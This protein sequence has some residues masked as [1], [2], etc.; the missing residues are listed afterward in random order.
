[1]VEEDDEYVT[2]RFT[3]T[4]AILIY[5]PLLGLL[6]SLL[7]VARSLRTARAAPS[8]FEQ[9]VHEIESDR[10]IEHE[11]QATT[12]MSSA[13]RRIVS[14][15]RHPDTVAPVVLAVT[16]KW[17]SGKSSLMNLVGNIL[18]TYHFP[19]VW[20]NAWHHQNE[21]HL[22]ASLLESIRLTVARQSFFENVEFRTNLLRQRV[23]PSN[24]TLLILL[25]PI[26][27]LVAVAVSLLVGEIHSGI[28]VNLSAAIGIVTAVVLYLG[29]VAGKFL[30][31]FPI[32]PARLTGSFSHV[33]SVS[34]IYQT[35]QF[36]V[37]ILDERLNRYARH[38]GRDGWL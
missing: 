7:T 12:A 1:M 19:C 35:P 17:G 30:K 31:A 5:V 38:L 4:P 20:F 28:S 10:P 29:Q 15:V 21:T 18:R 25:I 34:A 32:S 27:V 23:R 22:F 2:I 6:I 26:V 9:H 11:R 33:V 37:S 8:S 24:A 13:A 36:S 14:L 3:A 16:G